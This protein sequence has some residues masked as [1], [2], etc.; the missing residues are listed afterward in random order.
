MHRVEKGNGTIPMPENPGRKSAGIGKEKREQFRCPQIP[1]ERVRASEKRKENNSDARKSWKKECGHRKRENRTIPMPVNP[2]NPGRKSAG[3][4]KRE[5]EQFRCPTILEER[6]RASG[7]GKQ[8]NSDARRSRKKE[9][10]H[11]K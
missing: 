7:K 11:R 4:G 1:E 8:N 3:I 6:V 2:D 5:T 9:C 10:G